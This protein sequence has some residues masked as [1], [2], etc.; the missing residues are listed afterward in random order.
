MDLHAQLQLRGSMCALLNNIQ[1]ILPA[2]AECTLYGLSLLPKVRYM[3]MWGPVKL[4]VGQ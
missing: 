4:Q 1:F 2:T 3:P